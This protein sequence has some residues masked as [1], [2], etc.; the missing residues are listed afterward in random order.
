MT[1]IEEQARSVFLDALEQAPDEWPA[2][3]D[4]ACGDSTE[5]RARVAQLLRAHQATGTIH[6]GRAP[7]RPATIDETQVT[8]HP[9]TVIGPYKLLEQIGEGGFGIVF[10]AEQTQPVKRQVALKVLKPGMDT[11]QVVARFEAE[12]QALALMDHPN[13]ARVFDGGMT[14]G[15]RNAEFG[16]RNKDDAAP[17]IPNSEFRIPDLSA[18]RPYFVMELVRGSPI[19]VYCDEHQLTLPERLE[20]FV[21]VCQAVQH[22]H[23]KGI[24]H[25]DIKPSN[26]LVTRHDPGAPGVVKVIDF[27]VA[28]AASGLL[29]DK[30]MFTGIAQ[31]VGTPLYMSPEQAARSGLDVDTRS[32]IY[33]LGVLL[34][35]L[36]TGTT[37]FDKARLQQAAYD[38]ILRII[39]EEEP[40]K[41]STRLSGLSSRHA[42]RAVDADGTRSVPAT[43]LASISAVR[44]MEPHKLTQL[45]RGDLD[46][47]V[48]KALEKDRTRRYATAIGLAADVQKYLADEPVEACPPSAA[49]RFRKFARRNKGALA[50]ASVVGVAVVAALAVLATSTYLIAQGK[51]TTENALQAEKRA[52]DDLRR[53][54]YFHRIALA[55]REL[56]VNNLKRAIELL[57]NCPEDLR[58]WE[59]HFLKRL[60]REEPTTLQDNVEVRSVAFHPDGV[61][62]A[63]A[64]GDG[65]V[66]VWDSRTRRVIRTLENAHGD[67]ASCVAFH[68]EGQY[69]ASAGKDQKVKVWDWTSGE[70]VFEAL[71]DAVHGNGTAY[72]VAFS[73]DGRQLA[74][75]SNGDVT[76][77]DW[78]S[79]QKLHTLAGD[80]KQQISV[81]YCRDGR[82]ASG[83]WA[84][85]V[86]LWDAAAGGE[87]L[88]AF[89]ESRRPIS[90]LAFDKD[91]GRLAVASFNR[92]VEVWNT[93]TCEIVHTLRHTG[94]V[95][96]GVAFTPDGRRLAS[97]GQDKIVRVWD[98]ASD[99]EVLTLRGHTGICGCVAFSPD[100]RRLASASEDKTICVWD[101]SP[102]E[103]HEGQETMTLEAGNEIWSL[104]VSPDG[105]KMASAG[106]SLPVQVRNAR[107]GED[108][109][110]FPDFRTI[111]FCV[112][113]HG[114]R[115]AAA[116]GNGALFTV[117]VWDAQTR[118]ELFALP[119]VRG[120]TEYIAVAYSPDGYLVTG[121]KDGKVRAW[122]AEN[123]QPVGTPGTHL[124]QI[125]GVV[126]SPDGQYFASGSG[127]GKVKVWA[128]DPNRPGEIENPEFECDARLPGVYVNVAFSPDSRW[129]ATGGEGYTVRIQE[130]QTGRELEPL[131]GHTGDVCSVAFSPDGRWLATAGEDTT[132]R[133]WD[134]TT[135]K[136]RHTLRGHTGLVGSLVFIPQ[137]Q[138]LVSGSHDHT[139][140]VWDMTQ[141]EEV[142]DD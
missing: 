113:W 15:V 127:D 67:H 9:G 128:W 120:G 64:C 92:C 118:R 24:I 46:W 79:G 109:V 37:P 97:T 23:Q 65:S 3:L 93:T 20:L 12:R 135:W 125:L 73:P 121:S 95:V 7:T 62:I 59:W 71:C 77:W 116:G 40:Q 102:L 117:K 130:V 87:P 104:A 19:T 75:G 111:V 55:H 50:A 140:K 136:P 21:T 99:Q 36:L 105:H 142:R 43:S 2:I 78:R 132:V 11:R 124:R 27:G 35:E 6:G 34:Y 49:Y 57:D 76:L 4:K 94:G 91:G 63:A 53:D 122:D 123:G 139:I 129:L 44:K 141:W 86:K 52:K 115:I 58:Q 28:K 100:G 39:R 29:T 83:N 110:E 38:E 114:Q 10:M 70:K 80:E 66:K 56:S 119:E 81:A 88:A 26:V 1:V 60:C 126:F 54:D 48:M 98:A 137:S 14:G 89:S 18:G 74:A 90:A 134:T 13:I 138:R 131:R 85:H 84:G 133:I 32:D 61:R 103:G 106:W 16:M 47:I 33:S 112:A 31:M 69:L 5:L 96:L 72:A 30:T 25:R 22:A 41:P 45:L 107:T 17:A 101:A 51:Q 82:L 8:E 68:P 42:P 108:A